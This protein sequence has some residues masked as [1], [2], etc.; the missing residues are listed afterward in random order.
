MI[1]V[2]RDNDTLDHVYT[3]IKNCY[4]GAPLPHFGNSDHLAVML[5]P[6]YRPKVK[7]NK[8]VVREVR[9]WPA[10]GG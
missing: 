2:A 3:N 7:Q 10:E 1:C 6:A 5:I 4:R 8:S 9:V